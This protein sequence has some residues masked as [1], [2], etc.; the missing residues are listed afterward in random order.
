MRTL[1]KDGGKRKDF[2]LGAEIYEGVERQIETG[3]LLSGSETRWAVYFG[4]PLVK[5]PAKGLRLVRPVRTE[6]AHLT[7]ARKVFDVREMI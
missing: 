2:L 5:Y 1:T 3:F 7:K 6:G 4:E